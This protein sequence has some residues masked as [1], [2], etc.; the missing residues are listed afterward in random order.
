MP[1]HLLGKKSWNV[2]NAD[3]IAKVKRDEAAA[4]ALEE[5]EEQ[6]MQEADAERRIQILRGLK[7]EA[8]PAPVEEQEEDRRRSRDVPGRERKRRRIAGEDDTD[9]DI[10]FAQESG[11]LVPAKAEMQM[12]S[13]KSSDAPITDVKG[14]INLFPVD[15][16]RHNLRKNAEVEAE[17]AKKQKEFEDQYTVRFS[18]AAGFKQA[19]GQKPWYHTMGASGDKYGESE[20]PSKD[21]WGNEDPRRKERGKMRMAA[22]DP[23]AAIQKG[24]VGVREVEKEKRKWREEKD[25]EIREIEEAE[26]RRERK[27]RRRREDD[28]LE[29]FSLDGPAKAENKRQHHRRDREDSSRHSLRHRSRSRDRDLHRSHSHRHRSKKLEDRPGW[30]AGEG[31]RYSSQFA[32][33]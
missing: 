30:E 26:R 28:D 10:R 7:V 2:Y 33:V 21:V 8:P 6:R 11:A 25:R 22:D 20:A 4:A 13:K 24:V 9:R 19:V 14:H 15:S 16:S 17:K 29:D 27:R 18:N 1:L 23:L 3:N 32:Q 31:G 12:K 5:E